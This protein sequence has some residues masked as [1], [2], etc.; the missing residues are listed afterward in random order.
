VHVQGIVLRLFEGL[1]S[2][3]IPR[4]PVRHLYPRGVPSLP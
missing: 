1:G 2:S 3:R 4:G